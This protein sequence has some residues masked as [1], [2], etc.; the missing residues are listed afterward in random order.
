MMRVLAL[1]LLLLAILTVPAMA[2]ADNGT[3][4]RCK[5]DCFHD[6]ACQECCRSQFAGIISRCEG[7]Y[8][9]CQSGCGPAAKRCREKCEKDLR[10]C[11]SEKISYSCPR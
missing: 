8:V 10:E 2:L 1:V 6:T 7:G 9:V 11:Q 4:L 5:I 3:Y